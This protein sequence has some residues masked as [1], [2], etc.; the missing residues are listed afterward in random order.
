MRRHYGLLRNLF[1]KSSI[2]ET[3]M[4]WSMFLFAQVQAQF[5]AGSNVLM[6]LPASL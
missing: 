6:M 2:G 1:N 3:V 5:E 4:I